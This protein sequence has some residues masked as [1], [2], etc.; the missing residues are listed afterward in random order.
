MKPMKIGI[1]GAGTMSSSMAL[2]F[3]EQGFDTVLH[4][5]SE[6]SMQ[7][8]RNNI[9]ASLPT[10]VK[11]GKIT[12]QQADTILDHLH[13]STDMQVFADC[14]LIVESIIEDLA[15]KQDYWEQVSQD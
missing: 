11:A 4:V 7:R 14:D 13:F 9:S 5:R 2:I 1:A 6:A 8:V 12:Q 3:M 10:D 15:I